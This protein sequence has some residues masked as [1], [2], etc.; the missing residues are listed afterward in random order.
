MG[1]SNSLIALF[2]YPILKIS[3][4]SRLSSLS[5]NGQEMG[6]GG[7]FLSRPHIFDHR[8]SRSQNLDWN[9]SRSHLAIDQIRISLDI[10]FGFRHLLAI[11]VIFS[12]HKSAPQSRNTGIIK[13]RSRIALDRGYQV[14]V[15]SWSEHGPN[16]GFYLVS[17]SAT[18][19]SSDP[20]VQSI[21]IRILQRGLLISR[22]Q[23]SARR[24][25]DNQRY[26]RRVNSNEV[27]N[28]LQDF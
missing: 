8:M 6:G 20:D 23:K 15:S 25:S 9:K 18:L 21:I 27:L 13:S 4:F 17:V 16:P 1:L 7:E 12:S 2:V 22:C 19:V 26:H 11:F 24:I 10:S 28:L 14:W 5:R 3:W